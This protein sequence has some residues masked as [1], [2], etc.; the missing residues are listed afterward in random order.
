M[1][2]TKYPRPRL[3]AEAD[4]SKRIEIRNLVFRAS[5]LS[6]RTPDIGPLERAGFRALQQT[7]LRC[8]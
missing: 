3:A 5:N 8:W 6:E 1:T 7:V 4:Y 2:E